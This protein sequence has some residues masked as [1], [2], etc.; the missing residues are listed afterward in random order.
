MLPET[1]FSFS[2]A[3]ALQTLAFVGGAVFH[4]GFFVWVAYLVWK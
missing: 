2:D 1:A 3:G 4:I